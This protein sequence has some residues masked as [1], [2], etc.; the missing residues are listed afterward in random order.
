MNSCYYIN[1]IAVKLIRI[2]G[3]LYKI[4]NYV[5]QKVLRTIHFAIF[6][7]DS[8]WADLVWDQTF[9]AIQQIVILQKNYIA[10]ISI[11]S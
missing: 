9:N 10:I 7:S 8:N 6:D 11:Q 5:S 4:R 3:L 2:N 1:D